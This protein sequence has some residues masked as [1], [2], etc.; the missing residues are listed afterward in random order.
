M[1]HKKILIYSSLLSMGFTLGVISKTFYDNNFNKPVEPELVDEI[2]NHND[3]DVDVDTK[4]S[5]KHKK[6]KKH[7]RRDAD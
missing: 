4:K 6:H 3:V 5:K 1:S 7:R 2:L